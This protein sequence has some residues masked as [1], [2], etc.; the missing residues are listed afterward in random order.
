MRIGVDG[1][2]L[3]LSAGTGVA[4]Y[5]RDLCRTLQGDGHSIDLVY[6]VNVPPEANA[7]LRETLFFSRLGNRHMGGAK[8]SWRRRFKRRLFTARVRNLVEVPVTGRVVLSEFAERVPAF[9]RILTRNGIFDLSLR[10]FKRYGRFLRVQMDRPPEIMHWTY[11]LPIELVGAANIYTVHDLVPLR[12]PH[13]SL[14]DKSYHDRLIQAILVKADHVCTVSE[15]ARHDLL[16]WF[17]ADGEK[18]TNSYQTSF[19]DAANDTHD[20]TREAEWLRQLFDVNHREYFLFYGAIEPKK[21]VGRLIQA[22]LEA[23]VAGP[24][25]IVGREGW[26]AEQELRV[27]AGGHGTRLR[28]AER[29]RRI[30]YLPRDIL[31]R[32]VAGARAVLFPSLYEGFGLPV[33]EGMSLGAPVLTANLSAPPEIGGNAVLTVDPY[34]VSAIARAIRLL[35]SDADLRNRLQRDGLARAAAFS[36]GAYASRL[37]HIYQQALSTRRM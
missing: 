2:N 32:L 19:A 6:D 28:S 13:L 26:K 30:D 35:D 33:L 22:Y 31:L 3:A 18:V 4:T 15:A 21:N 37:T 5:A 25:L 16:T 11:P 1:Y 12:L 36:P 23:D 17:D 34:D 27:L 10:H 29:I 7:G 20:P 9:D 14:E 24:L 8:L